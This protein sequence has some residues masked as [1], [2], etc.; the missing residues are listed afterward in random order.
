MAIAPTALRSFRA[1]SIALLLLAS[2]APAQTAPPDPPPTIEDA[3]H[4][5]SDRADII[6]AGQVVAIRRHDEASAASGYG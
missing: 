3:L 6:F 5:M 4:Q 2:R 1:V